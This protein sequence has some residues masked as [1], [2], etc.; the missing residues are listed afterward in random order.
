MYP[1]L[2]FSFSLIMLSCAPGIVH[3]ET[4]PHILL[5]LNMLAINSLA[6]VSR[7]LD[8]GQQSQ[9]EPSFHSYLFLV[10][11]PAETPLIIHWPVKVISMGLER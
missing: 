8:P 7:R 2:S 6:S 9:S 4:F 3:Q 5:G 1:E 11:F 10:P